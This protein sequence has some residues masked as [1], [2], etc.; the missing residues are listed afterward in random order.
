MDSLLWPNVRER[1]PIVPSANVASASAKGPDHPSASPYRARKK[2]NI[3]VPQNWP[4]RA[5]CVGDALTATV[6]VAPTAPSGAHLM[7]RLKAT[8]NPTHWRADSGDFRRGDVL[9]ACSRRHM[10]STGSGDTARSP[11]AWFADPF[12]VLLRTPGTSPHWPLRRTRTG[13]K[14]LYSSRG[15][16]RALR[17][18]PWA[19]SLTCTAGLR[20]VMTTPTE[21]EIVVCTSRALEGA[22]SPRNSRPPDVFAHSG[23]ASAHLARCHAA[24]GHRSRLIAAHWPAI[25]TVLDHFTICS[26]SGCSVFGPHPARR[27]WPPCGRSGTASFLHPSRS[28]ASRPDRLGLL[29]KLPVPG[30]YA[31]W[32]FV[33][34]QPLPPCG[35][36]SSICRCF[37]AARCARGQGLGG[38]RASGSSTSQNGCP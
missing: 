36:L 10:S 27:M 11:L 18:A 13:R 16:R 34:V 20:G 21:A 3:R 31:L 8:I 38:S 26:A 4:R 15:L 35:S 37:L 6:S 17:A 24:S 29:G 2:V 22:P 5:L 33:I 12:A 32:L 23:I 7:D 25:R 9:K 14:T 30:A 19:R 1:S 28:V